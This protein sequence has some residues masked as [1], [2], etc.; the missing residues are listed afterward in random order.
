MA[1]HN[2]SIETRSSCAPTYAAAVSDFADETNIPSTPKRF[3]AARRSDLHDLGVGAQFRWVNNG[4]RVAIR[5]VLAQAHL[6]EGGRVLDYGCG[7]GPYR[8]ELPA[9]TEY[10]GAD[11]PGNPQATVEIRSDGT[12]PLPDG[13]F[14]LILSTYALEHVEEPNT[15]LAECRRLLRPGGTLAL[16]VPVLMY[17][18]RDPEDYW[19][20]TVAGLR[21]TV[22]E[23]GFTISEMYGLLGLAA[24]AIQ[25]FQDATLW[26]VPNFLKR[27]YIVVMQAAVRFVDRFYS[28]EL[29]LENSLAIILRATK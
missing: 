15:Y 23:A 17:Y 4:T 7:T 6:P 20:W 1:R 9:R 22:E 21:K 24:A 5:R 28:D 18:H 27:V 14:D 16:A 10:V 12:V 3:L 25:V 8:D 29:R 13:S 26:R 2:V 11:I 19:R